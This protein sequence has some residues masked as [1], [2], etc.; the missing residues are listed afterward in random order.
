MSQKILYRNGR[1]HWT[2]RYYKKHS[3][4]SQFR[5]YASSL[6]ANDITKEKIAQARNIELIVLIVIILINYIKENILNSELNSFL[7]L[8]DIDWMSVESQSYSN[9]MK[10]ICEYRKENPNVFVKDTAKKLN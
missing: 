6:F 4:G 10:S 2:W 9:L 5:F 1:R 8:S 7:P 3:K